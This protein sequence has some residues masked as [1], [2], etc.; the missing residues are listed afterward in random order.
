MSASDG[1]P[2][3]LGPVA[4]GVATS[5]HLSREQGVVGRLVER[6][7]DWGAGLAAGLI[8]IV[9]LIQVGGRLTGRPLPWTEEATRVV[10]IWMVFL[11]L[12]AS[13][14]TADAARVTIFLHA[15][16][17]R[18]RHGVALVSYVA[19]CLVFFGVMGWT[20]YGMVRQQLM[21]GETIATLAVPMWV[22]GLIM[23]ICALVALLGLKASLDSRRTIIDTRIEDRASSAPG[24][25]S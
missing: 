17:R 21:M 10:F 16:P 19:C 12:A 5:S 22:V 9:V 13:I 2:G 8:L 25:K 24:S 23:P 6:V 14:R 18:L 20:G 3:P 1:L 11:G 7:A 4:G 15:L